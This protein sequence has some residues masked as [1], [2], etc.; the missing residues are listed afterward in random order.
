MLTAPFAQVT[1]VED[2][3]IGVT[4]RYRLLSE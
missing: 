1:A 2:P 3:E 4:M